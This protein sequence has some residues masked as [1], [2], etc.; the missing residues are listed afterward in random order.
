MPWPRAGL[1]GVLVLA[2]ALL[3]TPAAAGPLTLR[4]AMG[5]V[6][7]AGSARR[8]LPRARDRAIAYTFRLHLQELT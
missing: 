1:L 7:A 4:D 5:Q 2:A 6:D 3:A 8:W